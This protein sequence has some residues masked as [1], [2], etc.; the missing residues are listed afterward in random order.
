MSV[1]IESH[2]LHVVPVSRKSCWLFLELKLTTGQTGLGEVTW[3]GQEHGVIQLIESMAPA[4]YGTDIALLPGLVADR[5]MQMT[6]ALPQLVLSGF[7]Q[8]V[9]DALARLRGMGAAE[10]L[11]GARRN[12]VPLYAN[13]NRGTSDR[14]PEGWAIRARAAVADGYTALK[15]APFDGL[16]A[17]D[18]TSSEARRKLAHGI[19]CVA[20]VRDGVPDDVSINVDCH[21]RFSMV[22][23]RDVIREFAAMGVF[24]IE[25][26]IADDTT[27]RMD[28]RN[29]RRHASDL[30]I[31]LAGAET[32]RGMG[33]V[34]ELLDAGA[35]DVY[36][37]DIRN[38]GGIRECLRIAHEVTRRGL[39]FSIHNPAG[40]VLDQVSQS[41]AA[42]VPGNF[43]IERQ[44][45]ENALYHEIML[46][47]PASPH[48]GTVPVD[49]GPG[50]GRELNPAVLRRAAGAPPSADLLG[51]PGAGP[52]S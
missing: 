25:S 1:S 14:S 6:E 29:L 38:C 45:R 15:L 13:I 51:E 4:L 19:A 26:P 52:L 11:G 33:D 12:R 42:C 37:P 18:Q 43:M 39:E 9:L 35:W 41:A 44:Y 21:S 32:V 46:P 8:A 50:W 31:R 23:A 7:E 30:G 47:E 20:A 10:L 2:V 16:T 40:P 5:Q 3:F 49:T 34:I 36:L 17:I 48:V 27:R 24:W 28:L 22:T